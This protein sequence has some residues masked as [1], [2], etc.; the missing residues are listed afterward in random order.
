M[1]Q[2]NFNNFSLLII[3]LLGILL[4]PQISSGLG[5]NCRGSSSC[6]AIDASLRDIIILVCNL[7]NGP[8]GYGPNVRIA[9]WCD[10][11]TGGLAAFTQDTKTS[12]NPRKACSLL[13]RLAQHGCKVCGSIPL[14]FPNS[15]DVKKGQLTVNYVAE[16]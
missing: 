7:P 13:Q 3:T 2:Y 14:D 12:I 4:Y 9:K 6:G 16:C 8:A 10:R 15:N 5:I 11:F 1:L